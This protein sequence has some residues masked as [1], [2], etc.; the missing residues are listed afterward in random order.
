MER[1]FQVLF[2][3]CD[4]VQD[5]Q[6][7]LFRFFVLVFF[8]ALVFLLSG[9]YVKA[10]SVVVSQYFNAANEGDE[11][12]ELLV[13]DDNV[14][15]RSWTIRDNGGSQGAWQTAITFRSIAFWQNLRAGTV[16]ILF[17]RTNNSGGSP[18]PVDINP[19]DGFLMLAVEN[20]TYFSG[21]TFSSGSSMSIGGTGDIVQLRNAS[22]THIHALSHRSTSGPDWTAITGPKLNHQNSASSGDAIFVCPGNSLSEYGTDSPQDGTTWTTR[23]STNLTFGLPNFCGGT[24]TPN[25][26]FWR[27]LRG[28]QMTAQTV[29]ASTSPTYPTAA[30][31]FTWNSATDPV[32]G[33][34]TT[35]YMVV[36]SSVGVFG[37][38]VDGT[39]YTV[40]ATIAGGGEVIAYVD[41]TSSAT[42]SY[43]DLSANDNGTYCYRVYAYR[44]G[45]DNINGN[46]F[47][48][49]RGRAYNTTN[50]VDV[51]CASNPLPV[52]L[53]YFIGSVN[54]GKGNLNWS[55]ATE[56]NNHFFIIDYS[57]NG[58]DF[59]EL[60]RV[61]GAGNSSFPN[62]YSVI[63]DQLRNGQVFYR[64]FQVDFDGATRME[65]QIVLDYFSEKIE[66]RFHKGLLTISNPNDEQLALE[67]FLMDG[68]KI[69][70]TLFRGDFSQSFETWS[71]TFM[72]YRL[73][74]RTAV[75]SAC[76]L[77]LN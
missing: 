49:A 56:H 46:S 28:P 76:I 39:T 54:N 36:R 66:V 44:F 33:D 43:T 16:I 75:Y 72:I 50:F 2:S 27:S 52:E 13:I 59:S 1:M 8:F 71:N 53:L 11:W 38:P 6:R 19:S 15:M 5:V 29:S 60:V 37:T 7:K 18:N 21:G 30:L 41:N 17:H 58:N 42:H 74:S 24:S 63:D 34:N 10:Q 35:G 48:V 4:T 31:T 23:N 22:S 14:D 12:T 20:S 47:D 61:T 26:T 65:A 70:E 69:V 57:E 51:V 64:L 62:I 45:T 9:G 77:H 3:D 55:T 32:P 40:G 67:V 73:T 25:S 68:R